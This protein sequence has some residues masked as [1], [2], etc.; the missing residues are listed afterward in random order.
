MTG[1]VPVPFVRVLSGSCPGFV[2]VL[3]G[4]CPGFVRFC[5]VLSGFCPVLSGFCPDFAHLPGNVLLLCAVSN[6]AIQT[7]PKRKRGNRLRPSLCFGLLSFRAARG[8][9]PTM[10]SN[11]KTVS[12]PYGPL[13]APASGREAFAGRPPVAAGTC[14]ASPLLGWPAA[15]RQQTVLIHTYKCVSSPRERF[16]PFPRRTCAGALAASAFAERGSAAT[17]H[18]KIFRNYFPES[19]ARQQHAPRTFRKLV[20]RS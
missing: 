4:F 20:A 13:L 16:L 15:I 11:K 18:G 10:F 8:M 5:P 12:R 14:R 17:N 3:S 7:I 2:R 19:S 6:D 1:M 9:S